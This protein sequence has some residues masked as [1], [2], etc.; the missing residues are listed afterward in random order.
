MTD[1]HALP[2]AVPEALVLTASA[3]K[4]VTCALCRYQ[5]HRDATLRVSL[6]ATVASSAL[7][8]RH[9][10]LPPPWLHY[11]LA[12]TALMAAASTA[13]AVSKVPSV[14]KPHLQLVEA[15]CSFV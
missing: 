4:A 7:G 8:A 12:Q 13:A 3:S 10:A 11:T 5:R 6:A 9:Q 14:G 2:N 1:T 15:A